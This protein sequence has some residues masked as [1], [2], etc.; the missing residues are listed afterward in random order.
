MPFY[1]I[2][3]RGLSPAQAGLMLTAQ[4]LVM[5]VAAPLS[6][7]LSDR[8]GSRLPSTLGM[9]I[10]AGGLFL[11][12]RLSPARHSHMVLGLA[13][14]GLGTGIFISP[15]NSVLDG[16]GAAPSARASLRASWRPRAM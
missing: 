3:G 9:L 7:T 10:L 15:N 16:L 14:A 5:A 1:L 13:V 2:N 4:P 11:L 8:I 6:G 12:S